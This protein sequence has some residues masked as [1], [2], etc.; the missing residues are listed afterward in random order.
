MIHHPIIVTSLVHTLDH[1]DLKTSLIFDLVIPTLLQTRTLLFPS[2]LH[3]HSEISHGFW[4][5]RTS[6]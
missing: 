1:E 3:H 6:T 2:A 5:N 4:I